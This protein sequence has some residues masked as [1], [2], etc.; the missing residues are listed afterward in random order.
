[1]SE[2]EPLLSKRRHNDQAGAFERQRLLRPEDVE[3]GSL[4]SGTPLQR[5]NPAAVDDTLSTPDGGGGIG[6]R[7]TQPRPRVLT[8]DLTRGLLCIFMAIDHSFFFSGKEHPTESWNVH[9]DR[10]RPYLDSWY[11]YG[12]RFVSHLCAPGFSLLMG[13]GCVYFVRARAD[14]VRWGPATLSRHILTRA[15]V[16]TLVGWSTVI[17]MKILMPQIQQWFM[18]DIIETL[19]FGFGVAGLVTVVLHVLDRRYPATTHL[20]TV[21]V[22]ALAFAGV[23][24]TCHL[25]PH[26]RTVTPPAWSQILWLGGE[27]KFLGSRFPPMAWLPHVLYGVGYGRLSM[28]LGKSNARQAG[29]SIVLGLVMLLVFL[30]VRLNAGFGNLT[31]VKPE[32]FR[33]GA[34]EFLWTSKYPPDAA[35]SALFIGLNHLLIALFAI[36]PYPFPGSPAIGKGE[37]K[38]TTLNTSSPLLAFGSS[39]FFFYFVHIYLFL[40]ASVVLSYAGALHDPKDLPEGY[41]RPGVG[42]GWL[43]WIIYFA[44]LTPVYLA[45]RWYSGFKQSKAADSVWRYF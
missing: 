13:L 34:K 41:V 5:E 42:N 1:M 25:V 19:A 16:F 18:F 15:L 37:G 26:D 6:R 22:F 44:L 38:K 29:L 36:F 43:Y 30:G 3:P 23:A 31:P 21:A 39:A 24:L 40:I 45:C 12:L 27:Y 4:T 32:W 7:T 35:Y 28:R 14:G 8:F 11:H 33:R 20:S 10:H 17:P 9:P 2:S